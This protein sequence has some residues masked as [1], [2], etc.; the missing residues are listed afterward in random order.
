[1]YLSLLAIIQTRMKNLLIYT[2]LVC[3]ISSCSQERN[4]ATEQ[5]SV[6]ELKRF[7]DLRAY[8]HA[9]AKRLNGV[10]GLKKRVTANG[11][12]EERVLDSLNFE[13][14]FALFEQSDINRPA[15]LDK[16]KID[17]IKI[18]DDSTKAYSVS[19]QAKTEKLKTKE[20]AVFYNTRGEVVELNIVNSEKS[21]FSDM[22]QTLFYKPNKKYTVSS[23]QKFWLSKPASVTVEVFF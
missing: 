19:Y 16:Y 1:M 13:N 3:L 7:F 18:A 6:K 5:T 21:V 17:T 23:G 15:W 11:K 9:E 4:Q 10:K 14:E 22:Q 12:K 20:L 8:F 2:L